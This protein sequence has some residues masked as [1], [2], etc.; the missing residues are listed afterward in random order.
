VQDLAYA[1]D[2]PHGNLTRRA[3]H[4][5]GTAETFT[6]DALQ[7]LTAATRTWQ[8]GRPPVTVGY[9]YDAL[10]NLTRKDDFAARYEYGDPTRQNPVNAG[11]HAVVAVELPDG[12]M[13]RDFAYDAT[14]APGSL[15]FTAVN[16]RREH[17]R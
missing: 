17:A 7:R 4:V 13:V 9:A 12:R 6:F 14:A 2:D 8:D 10:G 1:Y 11:P 16:T 15:R 5:R 3:D